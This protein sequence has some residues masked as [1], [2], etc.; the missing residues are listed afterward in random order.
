MLSREN[1]PLHNFI[2]LCMLT[3]YCLW[4]YRNKNPIGVQYRLSLNQLTY[5][6]M[7][8]LSI[9]KFICSHLLNLKFITLVFSSLNFH[10]NCPPIPFTVMLSVKSDHIV[11]FPPFFLTR[12]RQ[13]FLKKVVIGFIFGDIGILVVTPIDFISHETDIS[14]LKSKTIYL[15]H[16][17]KI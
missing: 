6:Y 11:P 4:P 17:H 15:N 8:S 14:C 1:V 9:N 5:F 10:T 16:L 7:F 2:K 13:M 12:N 3:T